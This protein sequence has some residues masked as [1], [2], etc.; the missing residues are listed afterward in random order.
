MDTRHLW[1]ERRALS[2]SWWWMQTR[3]GITKEIRPDIF[4]V[5]V[6]SRR[7]LEKEGEGERCGPL[8]HM[9]YTSGGMELAG[10]WLL[11]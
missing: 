3:E 10:G 1:W 8:R 5:G 6:D 2:F 4:T 7:L 9:I 11:W